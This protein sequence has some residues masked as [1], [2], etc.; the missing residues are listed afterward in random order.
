M[1]RRRAVKIVAYH[2]RDDPAVSANGFISRDLHEV[3]DKKSNFYMIGSMGLASSIAAGVAIK[4]PHRRVFVLDG[5][6][7]LLMNLGSLATIGSM[8]LNLV[9]VVFDNR[10]HESTGGQPTASG[11]V[12]LGRMAAAAGYKSYHAKTEAELDDVMER[13]ANSKGPVF[14]LVRVKTGGEKSGRV[15]IPPVEIRRR[16]EL[17]L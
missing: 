15:D 6:G 1:I 14:V 11:S 12:K 2:M 9:H 5:D 16:F 17:S 4:N 3:L 8:K 10:A 13:V 7:N